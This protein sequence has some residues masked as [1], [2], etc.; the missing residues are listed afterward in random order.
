METYY[1]LLLD[2]YYDAYDEVLIGPSIDIP[3]CLDGQAV[4]EDLLLNGFIR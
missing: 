4:L 2:D 1:Q 3:N